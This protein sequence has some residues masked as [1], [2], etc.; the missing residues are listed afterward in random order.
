MNGYNAKVWKQLLDAFENG[1]SIS[2]AARKVGK[3]PRTIKRWLKLG[4]EGV[5]QPAMDLYADYLI[6]REVRKDWLTDQLVHVHGKKSYQAIVQVLKAEFA[7]YRDRARLSKEAQAQ[8]DEAKVSKAQ[9][10]V[11]WIKAR[12]QALKKGGLSLMKWR[13]F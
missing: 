8:V 7:E 4:E 5:S 13:H 2:A 11:E 1:D 6:A 12:T 3:D 10:E 9:A